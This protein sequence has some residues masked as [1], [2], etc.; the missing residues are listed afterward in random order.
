MPQKYKN[1][2][3]IELEKLVRLVDTLLEKGLKEISITGGEPLVYPEIKEL[4]KELGKRKFN[5]FFFHTNGLLLNKEFVQILNEANVTKVAVSIHSFD[6]AKW[7]EITGLNKELFKRL[8]ENLSD[9]KNFKGLVEI[10]HVVIKGVN[11]DEESLRETLEFCNKYQFKAKFLNLEPINKDDIEMKKN[12]N[13]VRENLEKIGCTGFAKVKTFRG[14]EDYLPI[15]KF[16]YKNTFGVLID[17]LCSTEV[18]CKNCYKSNEIFLTPD[19]KIKPCHVT[20]KVI[21]LLNEK[22]ELRDEAELLYLI[23]ESREYLKTMPGL[24]A[25]YWDENK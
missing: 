7:G 6:P 1:S 25:S 16:V 13:E 4:M 5:E 23:S 18:G 22:G 3:N 24:G 11:D 9:L 20:S 15:I 14:Q 19:F 10:K 17:L 12:L 8:E 21:D 2:K